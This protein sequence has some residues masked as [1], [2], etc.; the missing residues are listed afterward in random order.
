MSYPIGVRGLAERDLEEAEDWYN[1]QRPGLGAEF[2][3]FVSD[4][5]ERLS[6]TPKLYPRVNG[7]VRRAV[8][9]RFPYLVYFVIDDSKVVVLACLDSRRDP[10]IH[11]ERSGA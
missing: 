8:L 5:F 2:R 9:R 1:R 4:L 10:R 6:E 3:E 7:E 11:R